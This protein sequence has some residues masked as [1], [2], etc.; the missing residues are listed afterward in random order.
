MFRTIKKKIMRKKI[1]YEEKYERYL[2]IEDF[3][4]IS[5]RESL[6]ILHYMF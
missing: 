4:K 6:T 5:V 2:K 3:Q 1:I